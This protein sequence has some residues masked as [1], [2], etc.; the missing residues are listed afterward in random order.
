[1]LRCLALLA[2]IAPALAACGTQHTPTPQSGE[3]RAPEPRTAATVTAAD[4]A[5]LAQGNA[6][7]GGRLLGLLAHDEPSAVISPF[8]ISDTLAMTY[9]GARGRTASEMANALDFRLP[10][11][12]L[13]GAFNAL[14]Q[15]LAAIHG[16]S[17]KLRIAGELF[18]QHGARFREAF[19]SILARDYGT[20][21]RTVDFAGSPEASRAAIN[22]WV[23]QATAGKIPQLLGPGDINSLTRLV[24]T[25]AVY[26][27]ARWDSPFR[28]DDTTPA[29]FY[30]PTGTA[31][32]PTMHQTASFGY[33]SHLGYQVLELPYRDRRL[34]F[35]VLL[36]DRGGLGSLL[37]RIGRAGPLPL[38][39]GLAPQRVKL[40][41]PKML[42]RAHFELADVLSKLGM[43]LAFSSGADFSGIAG[44]P[45]ELSLQHVVH[46]AYVRVDEAG[47]EAA[48]ATG[49]VVGVT[50]LPP[51]PAIQFDV[52]RPFVFVLRDRQTQAILFLGDVS[53]P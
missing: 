31:Q 12:R 43:R 10:A 23:S 5:S 9:A 50:A 28:S 44:R 35:D 3:A 32:V 41:L 7:F 27:N 22:A 19:L 38:L 2:L 24:L 53:H 46:E 51:V 11:D 16:G 4:A 30:A 37:R 18:G 34:A 6:Q 40:A 1:M 8:S 13:H 47:T 29:P 17:T 36:P 26:L 15:A 52:N 33:A 21:I 39:R 20:G 48:A 45:G 42:L 14:E 25:D 49:A